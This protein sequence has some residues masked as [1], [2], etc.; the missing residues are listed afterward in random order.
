MT[1]HVEPKTI[2]SLFEDT[3]KP[4]LRG[5]MFKLPSETGNLW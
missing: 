1:F 3:H 5:P 4:I 2:D